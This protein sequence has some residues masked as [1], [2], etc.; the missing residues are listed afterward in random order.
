MPDTIHWHVHSDHIAI[1]RGGA[2]V[3]RWELSV[4]DMLVI[5]EALSRA[6][7]EGLRADHRPNKAAEGSPSPS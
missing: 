4:L 2:L 3:I 5:A 7:R 1:Y 6:A